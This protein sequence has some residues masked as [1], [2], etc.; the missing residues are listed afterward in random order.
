MERK[1]VSKERIFRNIDIDKWNTE[2]KRNRVTAKERERKKR[3]RETATE[4]EKKE[5][6]YPLGMTRVGPP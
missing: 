2:K 4:R 6:D 3:N 5:M 1:N